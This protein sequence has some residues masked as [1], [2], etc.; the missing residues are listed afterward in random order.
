LSAPLPGYFIS[1]KC[2]AFGL[3]SS[4]NASRWF[5]GSSEKTQNNPQEMSSTSQ[6]RV[7]VDHT[8]S[9]FLDERLCKAWKVQAVPA[10]KA[11]GKDLAWKRVL[12]HLKYEE[13]SVAAVLEAKVGILKILGRHIPGLLT[14][15]DVHDVPIESAK[16]ALQAWFERSSSKKEDKDS[17]PADVKELMVSVLASVERPRSPS[18]EHAAVR[19]L[20]DDYVEVDDGDDEDDEEDEECD[21]VPPKEDTRM[22]TVANAMTNVDLKKRS[23]AKKAVGVPRS[24]DHLPLDMPSCRI[25]ETVVTNVDRWRSYPRRELYQA[26]AGYFQAFQINDRNSAVAREIAHWAQEDLP[27]DVDFLFDLPAREPALIARFARIVDKRL[28]EM[29]RKFILATEGKEMSRRFVHETQKTDPSHV[30]WMIAFHASMAR[31]E[32]SDF[33]APARIAA[34]GTSGTPS[35]FATPSQPHPQ[36]TSRK[37]GKGKST[38]SSESKKTPAPESN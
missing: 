13:T 28:R 22:V 36:P 8:I 35:G 9:N 4:L 37:G 20:R 27:D 15:V 31:R 17:F 23:A 6:P 3:V 10:S 30:D 34:P 11:R 14:G 7:H 25:P 5:F 29:K 12:L 16:K 33:R 2:F 38:K 26:V 24:F 19:R 1:L 32:E 18:P 21:V